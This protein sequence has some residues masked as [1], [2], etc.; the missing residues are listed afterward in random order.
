MENEK[1]SFNKREES[2]QTYFYEKMA[3]KIHLTNENPAIGGSIYVMNLF[4]HF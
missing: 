1:R 4:S 3:N 2:W